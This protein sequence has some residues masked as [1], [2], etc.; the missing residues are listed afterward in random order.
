MCGTTIDGKYLKELVTTF[1]KAKPVEH[2]KHL[3]VSRGGDPP[4]GKEGVRVTQVDP[5]HMLHR[6]ALRQGL[7]SS[8]SRIEHMASVPVSSQTGKVQARALQPVVRA[9]SSAGDPFHHV[10]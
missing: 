3:V 4:K 10:T 9:T 5:I 1:G 7:D 2:P 8:G 6:R